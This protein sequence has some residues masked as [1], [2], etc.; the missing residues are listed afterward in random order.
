MK[1]G[2]AR[3]STSDQDLTTQMEKLRE[4]ECERIWQAKLSDVSDID[5]GTFTE[6]I[7]YIRDGDVL[8]V[9]RLDRLGRSLSRILEAIDQ[10]HRKGAR[11]KTLDKVLDTSN[12]SPLS[13]TMTNLVGTFAQL[14]RDLILD[15]TKEGRERAKAAGKHMGRPSALNDQA[16][17]DVHKRLK[18]GESV[19]SIARFH[20]VARTMINRYRKKMEHKK[21]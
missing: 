15:R 21:T 5:E 17:K 18:S 12:D 19:S 16:Q 11:I 3:A 10:I 4:A 1:I 2:Y 14:E 6:I 7:D 8:M 13:K 20:G 9:T